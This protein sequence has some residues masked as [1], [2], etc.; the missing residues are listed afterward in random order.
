MSIFDAI[1]QNNIKEVTKLLD[2]GVDVNSKNE[3]NSSLLHRAC[4]KDCKTFSRK[5]C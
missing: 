1:E 5:R 3:N 2:E 4:A